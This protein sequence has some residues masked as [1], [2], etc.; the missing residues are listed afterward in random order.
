MKTCGAVAVQLNALLSLALD[1]IISHRLRGNPRGG[2]ASLRRCGGLMAVG[3]PTGLLL[4]VV[5]HIVKTSN[6]SSSVY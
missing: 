2:L 5:I 4:V 1:R 6:V 3:G